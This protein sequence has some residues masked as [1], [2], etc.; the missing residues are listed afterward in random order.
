VNVDRR[1]PT[2]AE[3]TAAIVLSAASTGASLCIPGAL[4]L[5]SGHPVSRTSGEVGATSPAVNDARTSSDPG[6]RESELAG[7]GASSERGITRRA[8]LIERLCGLLRWSPGRHNESPSSGEA[9]IPLEPVAAAGS[10][11]SL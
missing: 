5:R 6:R 4:D 11:R 1:P 3:M 2:P 10:T 8:G 9:I 7:G